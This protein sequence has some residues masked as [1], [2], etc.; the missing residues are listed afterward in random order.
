MAPEQTIIEDLVLEVLSAHRRL[1]EGSYAFDIRYAGTLGG[2]EA[3][4]LVSVLPGTAPGTVL[5]SLTARGCDQAM[6]SRHEPPVAD[7]Q[8]AQ[9]VRQ[10]ARMLRWG[11]ATSIRIGRELLHLAESAD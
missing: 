9:D 7:R 1:G 3:E 2:L 10:F 11:D 8:L 6:P 4:G 5:A